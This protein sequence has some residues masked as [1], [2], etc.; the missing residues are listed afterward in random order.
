MDEV[1]GRVSSLEERITA[2]ESAI[3]GLQA[4]NTD[5]QAQ[6]G[7]LM[8]AV[9]TNSTKIVDALNQITALRVQISSMDVALTSSIADLQ[10]QIRVLQDFVSVN[11]PGLLTLHEQI[12]NNTSLINALNEQ[13]T[14]IETELAMKQNVLN[15]SCPDGSVLKN[16]DGAGTI[17]CVQ[18]NATAGFRITTIQKLVTIS[19]SFTQYYSCGS[20]YNCGESCPAFGP[21]T[22][23]VCWWEATCERQILGTGSATV[24][25]PD[26]QF[27][28]SGGFINGYPESV[29]VTK[30]TSTGTTNHPGQSWTVEAKNTSE[31]QRD[32]YGTANCVSFTP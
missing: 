6:I 31:T 11:V 29:T 8:S 20:Y 2:N 27:L 18:P 9:G 16:F 10:A 21:C 30:S 12:V 17:E 7:A 4:Q 3:N 24:T 28:A 32:I 15:G 1:V 23:I 13:I 26:G 14:Q 19:P 22:P 5:L 25:C